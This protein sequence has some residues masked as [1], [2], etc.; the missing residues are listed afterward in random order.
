MGLS[1]DHKRTAM[2]RR[3]GLI[4]VIAAAIALAL[5]LGH[6]S[7]PHGEPAIPI[8]FEVLAPEGSRFGWV[9]QQILFA[10]SPDG[11]LI[12]F[13][14]VGSDGRKSLWVRPLAELSATV[15]PGTEGASAPFWS[16]D[17]RFIAFFADGKL[18]KIDSLGG[19]PVALCD[20]P[21][22]F[23][24]GSWGTEHGILFS[25]LAAAGIS[26]VPEGG[27]PSKL[28]LKAD[29]SRQE[30][31]VGWPT[32]L[33]DGRHFLYL[34]RIE[35]ER[36]PNVRVAN[37]ADDRTVALLSN[38]TRAVYVPATSGHAFGHI[39]FARDGNLIAQL[40]DTDRLRLSGDAIPAGQEIS[41]HANV[42]IGLFSASNNGFLASRDNR[43]L[44]R[45]SWFDRSGRPMGSLPSP[46]K[47]R[48]IRI[49]RDSRKLAAERVDPHT[50]LAGIWI[51]D[52]TRD[53]L[54]RLELA[55]EDH[56]RA[57]WSPD[58]T[59]IA[60]SIGRLGHPPSVHTMALHGASEPDPLTVPGRTQY[61]EDWSPD[62]RV[63]LYFAAFSESGPG[64]W[65]VD[66][67]GGSPPRK[68]LSVPEAN[69][70]T[71]AQFSPDGRWIAYCR[72]E[73]GRPEIYL[74]S[75][76]E[77]GERIRISMSGGSRPRWK[78]DGKELYFVSVDNELIAT[79][80]QP[81]ANLQVGKPKPLFRMSAAGWH[82]YD[83]T[84][85]GERFLVVENL[86]GQGADAIV[87]TTSWT[88]RLGR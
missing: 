54:T 70:F 24:S 72:T 38:C 41:Q 11:R 4:A 27:G 87:V 29:A 80:I 9:Q 48:S 40:F 79:P 81:G 42:G 63:I 16:P 31:N 36:R 30:L 75:F 23:P 53:V 33:P 71:S 67:K 7:A 65:A 56:H 2:L 17:S 74:T 64:L 69:D 61:A 32:F 28:V 8:S 15:L 45:L 51:G 57:I 46:G 58:G 25:G 55:T 10:I 21:D 78:K 18:K 34:G 83:V 50:G 37:T 82:D 73:L 22:S 88:S 19:Q 59:Q 3:T 68:L 52:L 62:G 26:F 12:V 1:T 5:W 20:V 66:V 77:P 47:F 84:A 43:G 14:A 76:Q 86:P 39:L 13:V 35:S 49:S 60:F 44:T 85:D 6:R